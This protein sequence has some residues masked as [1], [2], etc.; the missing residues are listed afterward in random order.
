M[1]Q[2]EAKKISTWTGIA[3]D[4]E[5]EKFVEECERETQVEKLF[6]PAPVIRYIILIQSCISFI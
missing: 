6:T 2:E 4:E 3:D 5:D 1:K